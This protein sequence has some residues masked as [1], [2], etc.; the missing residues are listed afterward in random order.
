MKCEDVKRICL[1]GFF[2]RFLDGANAR[3]IGLLPGV[4]QALVELCGNTALAGCA[5][6]LLS[7]AA[8]ECLRKLGERARLVN[9]SVCPDFDELF[10]RNLYL[11]P[12]GGE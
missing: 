10:M 7:N 11:L 5:D 8:V 4:P 6:A 3:E 2:G 1:G 12:M 9:L